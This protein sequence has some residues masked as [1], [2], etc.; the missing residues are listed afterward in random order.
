MT[1]CVLVS[2]L[3]GKTD[4][5]E[6]LF[7]F[8]L[9]DSPGAVFI[10]GDIL[11]HLASN[12]P[13]G[14]FVTDYIFGKLSGL[15]EAMGVDYPSIFIIPGNDDDRGV[16]DDL[17]SRP[18]KDLVIYVHN[19]NVPYLDWSVYGYAYTPPSPF[20]LKD[21]E[22]Y[23]VSRYTDPG[24]VSP[25]EGRYSMP[26]SEDEKRFE[27]IA[28]DLV[29][30]TGEDDLKSAAFL[31]HA[32]PYKTA[33]D[34]AGLDGR[35]IEGIPMDVNVG[36]IAIRRFIEER[37]PL[38]TMHGHIHESARLSGSWK[39]RIGRTTMLSAAHDGPELSVVKFILE[40]PGKASR[41]LI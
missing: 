37:Q 21:W 38:L 16:E 40:D 39:D 2:D 22:R 30:L 3:H 17:R 24:C 20:M 41:E 23:D 28:G 29:S 18:G 32:P 26:I 1:E 4:R 31:F 5:Y 7:K 19:R 35:M 9:E 15:R 34:R 6:K 10:G 12:G 36:S 33:L 8:I 13:P 11:P 14:N 25:E 27:T